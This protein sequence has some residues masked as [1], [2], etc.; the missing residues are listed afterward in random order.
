MSHYWV[1]P[2]NFSNYSGVAS[3]EKLLPDLLLRFYP[4]GLRFEKW[5]WC[6]RWLRKCRWWLK[7]ARLSDL[8]FHATRRKMVATEY[9]LAVIE[10][11]LGMDFHMAYFPALYTPNPSGDL[12]QYWNLL[13]LPGE[14]IKPGWRASAEG[15]AI[16][17]F[18]VFGVTSHPS[19]GTAAHPSA[20][21]QRQVCT[22][23]S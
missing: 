19:T 13:L 9:S 15:G 3:E 16:V 6:L 22:K 8:P 12:K 23:S 4:Q 5:E 18:W 21:S 1:R 14:I 17:P 20:V 10:Q 7:D 11:C 2:C